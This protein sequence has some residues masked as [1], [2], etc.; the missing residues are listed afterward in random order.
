MEIQDFLP[1]A[2]N[3]CLDFFAASRAC[4]DEKPHEIVIDG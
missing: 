4:F 1:Q 3:L 2:V